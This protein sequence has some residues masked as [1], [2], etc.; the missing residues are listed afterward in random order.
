MNIS[1]QEYIALIIELLEKC[2]DI[3]LIDLVYKL[4]RKSV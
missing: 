4:L 3:P 1:K 2:N